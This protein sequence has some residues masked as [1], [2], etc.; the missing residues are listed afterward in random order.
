M[1]K[2]IHYV[3]AGMLAAAA[4]LGGAAPALAAENPPPRG[5]GHLES[6]TINPRFCDDPSYKPDLVVQNLQLDGNG[7][8]RVFIE[9]VGAGPAKGPFKVAVTVTSGG[10]SRQITLPLPASTTI[11]GKGCDKPRGVTTR[12]TNLPH[13]PGTIYLEVDSDEVVAEKSDWNN[14]RLFECKISLKLNKGCA[15]APIIS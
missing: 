11:L 14:L 2:R 3:T 12:V 7:S 9:N 5:P 8:A 15:E 10:V 4:L 13:A 1:S 6:N